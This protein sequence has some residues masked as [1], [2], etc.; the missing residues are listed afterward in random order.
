MIIAIAV[1]TALVLIIIGFWLFFHRDPE[2]ASPASASYLS[3]ADGIVTSITKTKENKQLIEKGSHGI[4]AFLE[5]FPRASIIIVITM[6][7]WHVHTQRAPVT[8]I[9]KQLV[10]KPGKHM[11][12]V[13]NKEGKAT[14]ENEHL[15]I[16]IA[17]KKPCK[18][19]LIA[20][21]MA[22]RI[23]PLVT[24][25]E[26]VEQGQKIG[27]IR[28]GSQVALVLPNTKVTVKKGDRVYAGISE[29]AR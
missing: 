8:G 10:H 2:R 16:T 3:P 5:D 20:G 28:M 18:V 12:A 13:N 19:Y 15:G 11:N 14:T 26:H 9:I 6:N 1:T 4:T 25:G 22:R 27:K 29:I 24:R 17:G 7:L 23:K 21:L